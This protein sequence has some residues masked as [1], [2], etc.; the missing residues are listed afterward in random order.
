MIYHHAPYKSAFDFDTP[1]EYEEYVRDVELRTLNGDLV[2]SF[3]ELA[4]ANFLTEHGIEFR[5]EEPYEM[6]TGT[7]NG[8]R[9]RAPSMRSV[10]G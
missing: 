4:I 10:N 7:T 3:E 9:S 6:A 8:G 2:K 5:Y 1:D